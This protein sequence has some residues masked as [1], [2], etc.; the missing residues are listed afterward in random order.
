MTHTIDIW[1]VTVEGILSTGNLHTARQLA[2]KDAGWRT[3]PAWV[4]ETNM[5][6]CNPWRLPEVRR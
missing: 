6:G 5:Q 2:A 4:S 3:I 1:H